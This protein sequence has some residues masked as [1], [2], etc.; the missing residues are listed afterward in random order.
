MQVERLCSNRGHLMQGPLLLTPRIFK[1]D[2]GF[3]Y[4]SWNTQNFQD[5]LLKDG[6]TEESSKLVHFC[7]D[8]HSRSKR[9]VLR[10]LHYQLPPVS[11][12][13]LV[14]CSLGLIYDVAVDLRRHSPDF[15]KW[16]AAE[17][18][19]SNHQ[20]LWI[21]EGF[22]HG[23]LALSEFAEVQY[24]ATNFWSKECERS[25]H[26]Q[27]TSLSIHW[28]LQRVGMN[29]PVLTSK[30]EAALSLKEFQTIGELF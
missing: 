25:L 19:D 30:D 13:K 17:L 29:S 8:N 9:G 28:P 18:S 24:K 1:D 14:R 4:E 7:Q 26:W 5:A 6:W 16:V 3:F 21:P 12:G 15:G 23:F 22:A 20:Q 2:R 10:S 11:Q 27:D